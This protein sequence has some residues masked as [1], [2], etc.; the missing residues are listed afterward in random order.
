MSDKEDSIKMS[1]NDKKLKKIRHSH[2][3]TSWP[4]V[5]QRIMLRGNGRLMNRC[6]AIFPMLPMRMARL[7]TAVPILFITA[8]V[9]E[10]RTLGRPN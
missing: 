8:I 1:N 10:R 2:G 9:D 5:T 4:V 6:G 3:G 7:R